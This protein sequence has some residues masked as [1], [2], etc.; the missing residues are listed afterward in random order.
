M[1]SV[2]LLL[3][4][5]LAPAFLA[6]LP[7]ATFQPKPGKLFSQLQLLNHVWSWDIEFKDLRK[8]QLHLTSTELISCA[9]HLINVLKVTLPFPFS[10]KKREA[11]IG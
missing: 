5:M 1:G 6:A 4:S 11:Q 3:E 9:K 7:Q 10:S 2:L 8:L